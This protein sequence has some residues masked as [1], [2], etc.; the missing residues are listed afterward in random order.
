MQTDFFLFLLLVCYAGATLWQMLVCCGIY[1]RFALYRGEKNRLQE[2]EKNTLLLPFSV[3][4][5][6][7]N[8]AENLRSHLPSILQQEYDGVWELLVV[9][10][11]SSDDSIAVLEDLQSVY[12]RLRYLP[13]KNKSSRGKKHA[14]EQGIMASQYEY[15]LLTDADC[16]P[17]GN[18]WLADMAESFA[19]QPKTEI[20]L[21]YG[22][23]K[24]MPGMLNRWI[25]FETAYTA[26]QY[27]SFALARMPYMGVGRNLAFSKQIFERTGGFEAHRHIPS[28]DDDLL[29]NAAAN[30]HNTAV[31]VSRDSYVYSAGKTNW[32][33]WLAQKKRHLGASTSYRPL[34]QWLLASIGLSLVFHYFFLFLL[35]ITLKHAVFALLLYAVRQIVLYI[36][37][38]RVF[39]VLQCRDLIPWIP[40][41][42]VGM[43]VYTGMVVPW[44]LWVKRSDVRWK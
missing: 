13:L 30:S 8:E 5:C 25:R 20:V 42:D 4:I 17:V 7:R 12:P 22:P 32:P 31:C 9:D 6:A 38:K 27:F 2:R 1:A 43:A 40:L 28:G 33:A 39:R 16:M 21:G 44:F 29:V 18:K 10:D 37:Y 19:V 41:L 15:L 34:H 3:I 11:D 26:L 36:L 35:L 24:E 14:L 23:M